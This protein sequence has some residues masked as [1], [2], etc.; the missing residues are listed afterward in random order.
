MDDELAEVIGELE[1]AARAYQVSTEH[2]VETLQKYGDD[3]PLRILKALM[4]M[5]NAINEE[6][7]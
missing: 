5:A 4:E 1:F 2:L 7:P 6:W 3:T